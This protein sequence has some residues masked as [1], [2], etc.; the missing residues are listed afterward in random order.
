MAR[1]A[2]LEDEDLLAE[3]LAS[4]LAAGGH[5][6]HRFDRAQRFIN[7]SRHETFDLALLDWNL[8]DGDGLEVLRWCR[9]NLDRAIPIVM[10]TG[11]H[12]DQDIIRALNSGADDY[13]TKPFS[14]A[15]VA[16]RVEAALR[17]TQSSAADVSAMTLPGVS[18]DPATCTVTVDGVSA[19]LTPKEFALA[20]VFLANPNRSLSRAYLSERALGKNPELPS[21]SLD[22]QVGTLKR[23]L[24]LVEPRR[25]RLT[26]IYSYGYRLDVDTPS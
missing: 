22:V 2:V 1:I 10:L 13:I 26:S 21:R 15:I 23:K 8:P 7:T 17:R 16:A 24:K 18:T 5:D 9:D 6:V 3:L 20:G 14:P 11:R 4:I 19:Q 25:I 12:A